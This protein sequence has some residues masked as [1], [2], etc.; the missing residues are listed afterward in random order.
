MS[1]DNK[2]ALLTGKRFIRDFSRRPMGI[3]RAGVGRVSFEPGCCTPPR[4]FV[5]LPVLFLN[6]TEEG[7]LH[8]SN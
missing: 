8:M 3:G 6:P 1:I 7:V 5:P 4:M 2:S